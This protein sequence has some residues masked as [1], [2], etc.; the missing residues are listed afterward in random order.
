MNI[1]CIVGRLVKD[2]E[3]RRTQKGATSLP[4]CVAVDRGDKERTTDFLDCQ[5]WNKTAE[6]ICSYFHKGDPIEIIGKLQ[7]RVWQKDDGTKVKVTEII[8]NECHFVPSSGNKKEVE[9]DVS[10]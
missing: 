7:T 8:V 1:V 6:F 9:E 5:A 2:P 4:F 10:F 3:V